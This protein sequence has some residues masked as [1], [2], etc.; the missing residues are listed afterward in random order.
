MD[1]IIVDNGTMH[2][3][4]LVQVVQS[5]PIYHYTLHY[6]LFHLGESEF[7]WHCAQKFEYFY[8]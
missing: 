1:V 3:V 7:K 8:P 2:I 4:L 5:T 6:P